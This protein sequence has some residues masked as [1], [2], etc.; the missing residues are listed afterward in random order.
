VELRG[1]SR[2]PDATGSSLPDDGG[3]TGLSE[4]GERAMTAVPTLVRFVR[5][6]DPHGDCGVATLATLAG[7]TYEEALAAVVRYQPAVLQSGLNWPDMQ[8]AARRLGLKTRIARR[9]TLAEDTGILRLIDKK[10][11]EHFVFLW[12]GRIIEG[13][14]EGWMDPAAYLKQYGYKP[15]ALMITED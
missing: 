3:Y 9:Y 5:Q 1:E 11:D 12:A 13:D 10:K 15:A 6:R 4:Q 8:K 2:S 14:G 7:V